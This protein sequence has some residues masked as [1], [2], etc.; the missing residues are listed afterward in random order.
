MAKILV[1]DDQIII[2]K[3]LRFALEKCGYDVI[4]EEDGEKGIEL[5]VK[6]KPEIVLVDIMLPGMN[7][8][9]LLKKLK[10]KSAE[11]EV[12]MITGNEDVENNYTSITGRSF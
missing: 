3:T 4:D 5:F 8:I 10:E 11:T 2:R 9:E 6:E 7:G 12:I 1:I